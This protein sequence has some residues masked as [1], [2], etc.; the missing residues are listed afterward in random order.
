[1]RRG[2]QMISII[3][4]VYDVQNYVYRC[5]DS[6]SKQTYTDWECIIVNDGSTDDSGKICSDFCETETRM[7]Y[8]KQKNEGL[9]EARNTGLRYAK[10]DYICFVDSDDWLEP[11]FLEEMYLAVQK[12]NADISIC[13]YY[14]SS[15]HKSEPVPVEVLENTLNN[16]EVTHYISANILQS[17]AWN[18]MYSAKLFENR[19]FRK[20]V[21]FEDVL[22][23]ND[24]MPEIDKASIVNK[25]LYHYYM[26]EDSIIHVR[27][28]KREEDYFNAF[29]ERYQLEYIDSKDKQEILKLLMIEFYYIAQVNPRLIGDYKKY[30]KINVNKE[31]CRDVYKR[32]NSTE[33][34]RFLIAWLC[35]FLY[36][37]LIDII[38]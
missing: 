9:S 35:P 23:M 22:M 32:M 15:D 17:F 3:V 27:N 2:E 37:I 34:V 1:M 29:M 36:K 7:T 6:I 31:E 24:M 21:Y 5:L 12:D 20:G 19:F 26:R 28:A 16:Q 11:D 33:K 4:P 25:P 8:I 30:I 14:R 18:K 38:H 10:G 13:G